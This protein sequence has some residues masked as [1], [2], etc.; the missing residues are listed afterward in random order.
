[1]RRLLP[2]L[3]L[4]AGLSALGCAK[5]GPPSGGPVD[6]RPPEVLSTIPPADTTQVDGS[7]P[8]VIS[9]S[10]EVRRE[11]LLGAFSMSPPPPG[12]VRSKWKG[13]VLTLNFDP[14]L[15]PDRTYVLTFGT[16]L[17][18]M[19]GNKLEDAIRLAFST[20][21]KL[22]QATV[23]GKLKTE[24]GS[25]GWNVIGYLKPEVM[26]TTVWEPNPARDLP[27]ATTQAGADGSWLLSN[28][29]PGTWRVFAYKDQDKDRLH[30]PWLEPLAVPPYDVEASEDSSFVPRDVILVAAPPRV[31]PTPVR[32]SAQLRDQLEVKFDPAPE[33]IRGLFSLE[34]KPEDF[35]LDTS[36]TWLLED[37]DIR[38]RSRGFKPG[39]STIVQFKLASPPVGNMIWL[40]IQGAYGDQEGTYDSTFT[41]DLRNSSTVD[42]FP[43]SL[44]RVSPEASGRL[45][46]GMP[47]VDIL[48]SEAMNR[49]V[50]EGL[51]L[52]TPAQD[53]IDA[54]YTWNRPEQLIVPMPDEPA[55]GA[56]LL[57]LFGDAIRDTSGNALRDSLLSYNY[58]YLPEDSL[59][60]VTGSVSLPYDQSRVHLE[61]RSINGLQQPFNKTLSSD[62]TFNFPA[63][64][65][66]GWLV[67][68]WMDR[69]RSERFFAGTAVPFEPAD[70]YVIH[71]DTVWV[72]A[73]WESGAVEII[74]P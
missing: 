72:R 7:M 8:I 58:I 36:M 5:M 69:T 66:G 32:V 71:P 48:F 21:E 33:E 39:D 37:E 56:Y 28:L 15:I 53:T 73:R 62:G 51:K 23:Q 13:D 12:R 65:A 1:M 52:I 19:R 26:D 9:F 31:R 42:T 40:R 60:K 70:P 63:I 30:T 67:E 6:K 68:G 16:D 27:D 49:D 61:F 4:L 44:I 35:E 24:G 22:D 17:S 34:P 46:R 18:D 43:P 47:A 25:Q 45:H 55:G 3:L 38:F 50:G 29:R 59:G 64:P 54:P 14:P 74:F 11:S 20:G 2:L 57:M 10:E 41:V